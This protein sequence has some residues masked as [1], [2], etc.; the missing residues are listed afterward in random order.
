LSLCQ[1]HSKILTRT[2]RPSPGDAV[3]TGALDH[4]ASAA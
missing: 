1:D 3:F 2:V 4:R